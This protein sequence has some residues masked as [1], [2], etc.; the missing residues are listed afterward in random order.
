M[1][2]PIIY[3]DDLVKYVHGLNKSVP[4]SNIRK[5]SKKQLYAIWYNKNKMS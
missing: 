4:I 3:K 2:C 5:M 1:R